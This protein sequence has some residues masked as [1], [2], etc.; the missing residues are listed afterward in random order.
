MSLSL[1]G[2]S[3][4]HGDVGH[5]E[6]AESSVSLLHLKKVLRVTQLLCDEQQTS[7][8]WKKR[9]L[10]SFHQTLQIMFYIVHHNVD[11]VHV[12]PNNYFLI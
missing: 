8:T 9:L 5:L 1:D 2:E 6:V 10:H 3:S 4:Y 11:L 12:A 7:V